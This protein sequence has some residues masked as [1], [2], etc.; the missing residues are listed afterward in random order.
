MTRPR[1]LLRL[2]GFTASAAL[3]IMALAST[4]LAAT[5]KFLI[6]KKPVASLTAVFDLKAVG[7]T[8]VLVPGLNTEI[9]CD[10]I[11]GSGLINSGTDAG[12]EFFY[13]ECTVL[14][15]F[16]LQELPCSINKKIAATALILPTE[17]TSGAP[18]VLFEK[19][20]ALVGMEGGECPLPLD[21][22]FGGEFCAKIENNDTVAPRLLMSQAIQGECKERIN[23]EGAEGAGFKD[24]YRYGTQEEFIDGT[25]EVYFLGAHNGLTFGVSL[26]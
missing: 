11:N 6:A 13:E 5:P 24:K 23:L 21:N 18:A 9:N 7:R 26:Q 12:V 1:H 10:K 14:S 3:G 16:P 4:A 22:S 20:T 15:I 19:A 2:V 8:S 17:L 25:F